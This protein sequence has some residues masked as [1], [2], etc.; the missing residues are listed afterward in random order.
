MKGLCRRAWKVACLMAPWWASAGH[1]AELSATE[2]RWLQGI[3]P[4]LAYA[5]AAG[6]P[7]D[8]VVQPQPTPGNAPLALA[9]VDGRC[10]LV[11]SMRG[12]PEAQATLD[13]IEPVLLDP[14]LELMAAHELGHCRRYRDGNWYGLPAGFVASVPEVVGAELQPAYTDMQA[15]RREEGYGD[16]VGLAWTQRRHPQHYAALQAWLVAERSRELIPGSH[17][18]TLAWVRL[19]GTGVATADAPGETSIF[20]AAARLWKVGLAAER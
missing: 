8:I 12:N 19:A 7:L 2:Q 14:I 17:H 18:D 3:Q 15:T 13:R 20:D 10:K 11:F 4:V 16:L 5:R 1:S 6:L 9:F